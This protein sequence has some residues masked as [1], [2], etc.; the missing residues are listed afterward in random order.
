ME[1]EEIESC[2]HIAPA[3]EYTSI[4]FLDAYKKP[5]AHDFYRA[6][7]G[8]TVSMKTRSIRV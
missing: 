8:M 1:A 5:I 6:L 3:A 7:L 2:I 4:P